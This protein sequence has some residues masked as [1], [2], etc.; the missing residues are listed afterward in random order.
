MCLLFKQKTKK[1]GYTVSWEQLPFSDIT[2]KIVC[3]LVPSVIKV[4]FALHLWGFVVGDT[5]NDC[6]AV[7]RFPTQ[8]TYVKTN[9]F[10]YTK[11]VMKTLILMVEYGAAHNLDHDDTDMSWFLEALNEVNIIH[12]LVSYTMKK[13][14]FEKKALKT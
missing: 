6:V 5:E 9:R 13:E 14:Y 2:Y 12:P 10:P 3:K 8:M 4:K 7:E 11:D 1:M